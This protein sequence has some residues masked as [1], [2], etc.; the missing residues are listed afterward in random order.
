MVSYNS[1]MKNISRDIKK[2]NTCNKYGIKI[3]YYC[4]YNSYYDFT[5]E[6]LGDIYGDIKNLFENL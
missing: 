5:Y 1:Y 2:K 6:Y 3:L 4:G